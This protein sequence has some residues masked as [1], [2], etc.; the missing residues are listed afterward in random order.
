MDDTRT[1]R[2]PP[3]KIWRL[4]VVTLFFV[5]TVTPAFL[6]TIYL[7]NPLYLCILAVPL[8]WIVSPRILAQWLP[9]ALRPPMSGRRIPYALLL[10]VVVLLT[11]NLSGVD[12]MENM[13]ALAVVIGLTVLMILFIALM[14]RLPRS[15]ADRFLDW[16]D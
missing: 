6:L 13:Y 12:Y 15:R 9:S 7:G 16:L 1:R 5:A 3:S 10:T 14:T 4:V 11:I 8:M 2:T